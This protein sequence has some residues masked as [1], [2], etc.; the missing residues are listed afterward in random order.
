MESSLCPVGLKCDF[1]HVSE[2]DGFPVL[3]MEILMLWISILCT[4]LSICCLGY[5]VL[6]TLVIPIPISKPSEPTKVSVFDTTDEPQEMLPIH[7]PADEIYKNLQKQRTD[8][9]PDWLT[10]I[11]LNA[12]PGFASLIDA[13]DFDRL[14][15][16]F[17][18]SG[19]TKWL[20]EAKGERVL[21]ND[22]ATSM[23]TQE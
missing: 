18:E 9:A 5:L 12:Y 7:D 3:F 16:L 6:R 17:T 1:D 20:I 4:C 22:L 14:K 21:Y 10:V 8:T 11:A 19:L 2:F 15:A 23:C 13:E